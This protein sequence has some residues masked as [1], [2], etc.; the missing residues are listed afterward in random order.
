MLGD[1]FLFY[2]NNFIFNLFGICFDF[3]Y[4]TYFMSNQR[5]ADRGV[6]RDN[7]FLRIGFYRTENLKCCLSLLICNRNSVSEFNCVG[8]FLAGDNN[9][10]FQLVFYFYNIIVY[11]S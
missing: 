7:S 1:Y 5:R 2:L 9:G 4:I 6:M 3:Y 10:V 8:L 11:T